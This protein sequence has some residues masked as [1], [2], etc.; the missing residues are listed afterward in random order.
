MSIFLIKLSFRRIDWQP[1][2]GYSEWE[3]DAGKEKRMK[4]IVIIGAGSFNFTRAISRD[5][6]TFP[7]LADSHIALVDIPEGAERMEASRAIIDKM[8][9]QGGYAA[10]VSATFDRRK[11]LEG[12]DAV[13]ITIRND[14]TIDAWSKDLTIPKKF[15]VDTVVGDTRG[16]SGIFRFL[17][18]ASEIFR[19]CR[20]I[21]ELAPGALVLNYTNPM[22]MICSYIG[23]LC[24]INLTGLCHSVQGTAAML[25]GWIGAELSDVTYLCAGINHQ[26]YF[27]DYRWKGQDAYPLIRRA[28]EENPEIYDKER[29]RNEMF[30]HLGYYVTESSRH[31]SE[32]NPWFRKRQDLIDRYCPDTYGYSIR[33]I[34][35]R[36][37]ERH[38]KM[39]E[40]LAQPTVDL[41]RGREYAASILNAVLGDGAMFE[42]NGNIPNDG[43]ITN[44]PDRATVEVPIVASKAGLRAIRIGEMPRQLA[45]LNYANAQVEELAVEGC[46]EK[47]RRKIEYAI[48]N[49]P[50]TAAV[51]SLAEAREL[52]RE[53][54]AAND[55]GF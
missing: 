33:V 38:E 28:I 17:R 40:I 31:N 11:A 44:L 43:Y 25:A 42:F 18:S 39:R 36:D 48:M 2:G 22:N 34:T 35:E 21:E 37:A 5:I 15:G 26:A 41:T 45:V 1:W 10:T 13:I 30:L 12:A 53:L 23:R 52:A 19:I 51:C 32:Y 46:I 49:D 50:L 54:F 14:I 3:K 9:R 47:D 27:L 20:D 7:A 4:K 8:I 6:L 55:V 24:R 29:V 16:P